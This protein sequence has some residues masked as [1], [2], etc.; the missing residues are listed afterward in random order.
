MPVVF[1]GLAY[2]TLGLAL[3][4]SRTA[5]VQVG[6]CIVYSCWMT[7]SLTFSKNRYTYCLAKALY[8]GWVLAMPAIMNGLQLAGAREV[9]VS[10]TLHDLRRYAWL[11]MGDAILKRPWQDGAG[12]RMLLHNW[13]LP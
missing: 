2:L 12:Y 7:R 9:N 4:Q 13:P 1:A 6:A 5:W 10:G 3:T 11:A 8:F